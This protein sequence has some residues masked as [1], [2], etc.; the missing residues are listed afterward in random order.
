M[1]AY[2]GS[3][4]AFTEQL[5]TDVAYATWDFDQTSTEAVYWQLSMP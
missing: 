2:P 3:A 5:G 1:Q 4:V